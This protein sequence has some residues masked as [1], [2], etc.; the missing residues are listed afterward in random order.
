[1]SV[2]LIDIGLLP[3]V[4]EQ[5][6]QVREVLQTIRQLGLDD[7]VFGDRVED[8]VIG[9]GLR[10]RERGDEIRARPERE[11]DGL[12]QVPLREPVELRIGLDRKS[13]V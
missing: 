6:A 1:M 3:V 10:Q 11:L 5:V 4:R 7:A 2:H 12:L 13:V 9:L 8:V